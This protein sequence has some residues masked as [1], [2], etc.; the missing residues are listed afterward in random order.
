MKPPFVPTSR[1]Q[2][3]GFATAWEFPDTLMGPGETLMSA[4]SAE[5]FGPTACWKQC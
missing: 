5:R 3:V 2:S 4:D 1:F